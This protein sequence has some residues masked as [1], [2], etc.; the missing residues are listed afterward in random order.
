MLKRVA[1]FSIF[2]VFTVIL[3]GGLV[4]YKQDVEKQRIL[5]KLDTRL[6]A[7]NVAEGIAKKAGKLVTIS[8]N[9][10]YVE[11]RSDLDKNMTKSV[12]NEYFPT[13]KYQGGKKSITV[14]QNSVSGAIKGDDKYIFKLDM[15]LVNGQLETPLILLV[16]ID[17]ERIYRIQSLG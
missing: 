15:T 8:N 5:G 13:S 12:F 17:N 10:E 16:Y 2:V 11:L 4:L 1:V 9:T 14:R 6:D 3:C 7:F